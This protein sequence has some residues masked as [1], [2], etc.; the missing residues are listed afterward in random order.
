MSKTAKI[1]LASIAASF[2]AFAGTSV[3]ANTYQ[4]FLEYTSVGA[5]GA[6][7]GSALGIPKL[8]TPAGVVTVVE[9]GLNGN[10]HYTYLDVSVQLA[11]GFRFIDTGSHELFSYNLSQPSAVTVSFVDP[12]KFQ[13]FSGAPGSNP[14]FGPSFSNAVTCTLAYG[15][16]ANPGGSPGNVLLFKITD[17]PGGPDGIEVGPPINAATNLV[18]Q[19]VSTSYGWWFAA[20]VA[21]GNGNTGAIGARD[22]VVFTAVPEPETYTLMVAGLA[23]LG[24]A[25]RRRKQRKAR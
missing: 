1:A 15:C 14:P 11:S 22:F 10:G 5:F 4:S 13:T 21:N 9:G 20:D 18:N 19:L 17:N 25:A 12:S 3:R 8:V 2:M 16:G 24:F 6:T 23:L 7:S